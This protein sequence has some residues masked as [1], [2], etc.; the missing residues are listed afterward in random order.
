MFQFNKKLK[1]LDIPAKDVLRLQRSL[2]DV[3]IAL[4]GITA[5]L[6]KAYVCA[7]STEHGL[8]VAI[9][10]HLCDTNKVVY[11][12]N[13]DGNISNKEIVNLLH[14][15]VLFAETLGFILSDLGIHKLESKERD[16][17]WDSLP[18]KKQPKAI[19]PATTVEKKSV[20][21]QTSIAI[22]T[23]IKVNEVVKVIEV[24]TDQNSLESDDD[25]DLG[26]PRASALISMRR[27]KVPPTA[28]ELEEKRN[29]L[30]ESL[31]RFL[32]SL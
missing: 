27:K 2:S 8:R 30:R 14:E 11:Y 4:P 13:D 9:A 20:K 24:D 6:A 18:L 5:Q 29:K 31:G 16:E 7:F 10:F 1:R 26:L 21:K 32:S 17:L 3:Q 25:I 19:V 22:K 15:G 23:A 28:E 12:L